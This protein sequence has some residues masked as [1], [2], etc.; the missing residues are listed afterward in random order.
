MPT[1]DGLNNFLE[2]LVPKESDVNEKPIKF[3][4]DKYQIPQNIWDHFNK[5]KA[6]EQ[7]ATIY[8]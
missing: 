8:K 1:F 3:L 5:E 4:L 7:V 2:V 6:E